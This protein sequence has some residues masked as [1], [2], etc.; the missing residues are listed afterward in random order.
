MPY[1]LLFYSNSLLIVMTDTLIIKITNFSYNKQI[2][3]LLEY[4]RKIT[5][6]LHYLI[7]T[8]FSSPSILC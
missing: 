8:R 7:I 5:L 1:Q 4:M 2:N 3:L 6:S